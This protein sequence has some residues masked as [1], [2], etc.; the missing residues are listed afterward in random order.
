MRRDESAAVSVKRGLLYPSKQTSTEHT[1]RCPL[2]A[3]SG[4]SHFTPLASSAINWPKPAA[5][6]P[7]GEV[8]IGT[9]L[10]KK[11]GF[12]ENLLLLLH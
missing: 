9:N 5:L 10:S 1:S 12:L 2:S 8:F 3:K 11:N 6:A 4:P 7:L